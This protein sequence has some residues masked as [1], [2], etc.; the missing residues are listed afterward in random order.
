MDVSK[1]IGLRFEEHGRGP[2]GYDCWGLVRL[3]YE[4]EYGL[5]LPTYTGQYQDT[6]DSIGIHGLIAGGRHSK[7]WEE[8]NIPETGDVALL[9]VDNYPK[10]VGIYLAGGNMLH[11]TKGIDSCIEALKNPRWENRIVAYYRYRR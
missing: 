2:E 11:I 1:Y 6:S 10:H 8:V 3:F 5:P 4:Q 9:R 7:Y